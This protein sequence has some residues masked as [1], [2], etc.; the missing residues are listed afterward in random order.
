MN[1]EKLA[2][3]VV[4]KRD[5]KK[6]DFDGTKIAIAIKKGFDSIDGK[7]TEDDTNKIYNKTIEKICNWERDKIKIEEIQDLIEAELKEGGY[8]DVF[9]S[10]SA[11]REKR[12]QSREI[13]FEE[14]RKHKFLKAL[15]KIGL[16]TKDDMSAFWNNKNASQ[17]LKDYGGTISEEFATSY[18]I[19]KRFSEEHENGDIHINDI[20]YYPMGTT[21][22]TQINLERLFEN[23]FSTENSSMREPQN[24]FSYA[25][26]SVI[27]IESA[28]K[29]QHGE[30]SIPAFDYYMAPGVLKTFKKEFLSNL[31][32]VLEYTDYDKFIAIN[33]IE[34]EID[35]LNTISFDISDFY[36][37]T[38]DA[39]TLKRMMDILYARALKSTE[40]V[41][42]QAMEA[43]VHNLNSICNEK[44][45]TVNVGTDTSSEGRMITYQL[46]E[47]CFNGVGENKKAISPK[48]VFKVKNGV[49]LKPG[50]PNYDLLTKAAE[51]AKQIENISFAFLDASFNSQ[52][53]KE[54]DYNSEV[55]YFQDGTRV[56][57]NV[58]DTDK[59]ISGGRGVLSTTTINV[60]RIALKHQ[61]DEKGFFEE[62]DEKLDL[63]KDQL[64][65]RMNIQEN[66]KINNFP[67]ILQQNVWI[68]S[69]RIKED[70]KVRKSLKQGVLRI[71]YCGIKEAL[72]SLNGDDK[73]HLKIIETMR[74]KADSFCE[75]YNLNFTVSEDPKSIHAK[76]FLDFDRAIFGKKEGITDKEAY[77]SIMI[78]DDEKKKLNF[79][80]QIQEL[81]NGGH[82][83]VVKSKDILKTINNLYDA[84]I[85]YAKIIYKE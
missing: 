5:G 69:E 16:S 31:Y 61:G 37:F 63:V 18:L 78:I 41:V 80:S 64:L 6:V 20:E 22:N 27:A 51:L 71:A 3:I 59:A 19:K 33:G 75:K 72:V 46:L 66:K 26:L 45:T 35:K 84:D 13:F 73:L 10:F 48:I 40:K 68:D 17:T 15:E 53:Y 14:K 56:I 11:Y 39:D 8:N 67:F 81:E 76:D 82:L 32:T 44:I 2:S 36:R 65:E 24:I 57:D 25:M 50:D 85:G 47:S 77:E 55:A 1:E 58:L 34:R 70:D 12:A 28:Q 38:R 23:G 43:F 60:S 83:I 30:E 62:L 49:N 54:G 42:N 52:F 74:K 4:V 79:V 29:D 7:Y 21:Q 9:E